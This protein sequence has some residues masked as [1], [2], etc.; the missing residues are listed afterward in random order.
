MLHKNLERIES[1]C[2]SF[3]VRS[4]LPVIDVN[5]HAFS[6]FLTFFSATGNAFHLSFIEILAINIFP[7]T[8]SQ[9]VRTEL[10]VQLM[11]MQL[12]YC[13]KKAIIMCYMFSIRRSRLTLISLMYLAYLKSS[14]P[15]IL[16]VVQIFFG[17]LCFMLLIGFTQGFGGRKFAHALI[18]LCWMAT[19]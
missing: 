16:K 1:Y 3:C 8:E 11:V 4:A 6:H 19:A 12:T 5:N 9:K 13:S 17:L 18:V 10:T 14:V 15:G 7:Q 2:A